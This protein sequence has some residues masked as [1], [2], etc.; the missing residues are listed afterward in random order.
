MRPH[1]LEMPHRE[2]WMAW[3]YEELAAT[4]DNIGFLEKRAM[5]GDLELHEAVR[6]W[7]QQLLEYDPTGDVGYLL[8]AVRDVQA[9]L[10]RTLRRSY[11][12]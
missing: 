11:P 12:T 4:S 5:L 10:A 3:Q 6:L 2:E 9:R 7:M 1:P 8:R